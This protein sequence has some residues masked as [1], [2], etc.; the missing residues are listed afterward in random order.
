METVRLLWRHRVPDEPRRGRPARMTVDD[1]VASGIA[2]ADRVGNLS[3]GMR[4][5]AQHSG[6]PVMTLYSSVTGRDQL[7]ELMID[8]CRADMDV[9]PLSG[10]WRTRLEM[11][12]S[13]NRTLLE[14]HPWL[15]EFESER[16]ILGPGTLTKY[17]RELSS[18]AGVDLSDLD[19]DAALCLV[20]DFVRASVRA[21]RQVSLERAAESATD[22]WAREGQLLAK[23][24]IAEEFPL[25]NRIGTA[26]GQA[27]HAANDPQRAFEF[28]LAVILDGLQARISPNG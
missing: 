9:T 14:A 16:A 25:A 28:G 7:L 3:F 10:S 15:A 13:D 8:Q 24:G 26:T 23:L 5:V 21:I 18:I 22:W 20:I 6:V 2:V 27:H 1:V 19:K 12:A 4:E 17:E 11:V